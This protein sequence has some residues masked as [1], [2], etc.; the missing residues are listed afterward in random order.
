MVK[1]SV[2]IPLYNKEQDILTTITSVLNQSYKSFEIIIIDD[3]STDSSAKI[4]RKINDD[5]VKL[6]EKINEGVSSARNLGVEKSTTEYITFL[7]GDDYWHPHHLENLNLLI[8]KFPEHLWYGSAYEKKRN[9]QL[10]TKMDSPILEKGNHWIGEVD[11]F[12]RYCFKDS[13]VNSSSVCFKKEFFNELKGFN[14]NF[15]HGEDT[16]LWIRAALSSKLV[17]SNIVSSC[18]NLIGSNRSS[19]ISINNR[20]TINFDSFSEEEEKNS[21]LKK[22]LDLNRYSQI[23]KNKLSGKNLL[24]TSDY[25]KKIDL[26][27]LNRKQRILINQNNISLKLLFL[28]QRKLVSMGIRLSSF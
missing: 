18:N 16:D 26:N 14:I 11:E 4:V 27:N 1:F 17:F 24:L 13:L 12:F 8:T 5:R 19:D 6:F 23:I 28:I 2:V 20:H 9:K 10:T 25:L 15:S 3:G 22:Y 7:D 21:F